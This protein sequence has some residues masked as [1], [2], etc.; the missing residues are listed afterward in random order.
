MNTNNNLFA[1]VLNTDSENIFLN[2]QIT[3]YDKNYQTLM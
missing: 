2:N 1:Q 3:N